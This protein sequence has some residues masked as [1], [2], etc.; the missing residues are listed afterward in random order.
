L[1]TSYINSEHTED[2]PARIFDNLPYAI[3]CGGSAAKFIRPT[4]I[5]YR[6][7]LWLPARLI[8]SRS[9]VHPVARW[10]SQVMILHYTWHGLEVI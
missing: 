10:R 6:E 8:I 2:K 1:L 5:T 9:N 3:G 4:R 7:S